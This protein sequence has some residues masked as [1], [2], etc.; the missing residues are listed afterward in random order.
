LLS[1]RFWEFYRRGLCIECFDRIEWV[2]SNT[3]RSYEGNEPQSHPVVEQARSSHLKTSFFITK[4][5][6]QCR[7]RFF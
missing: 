5:R 1:G 6:A 3:G 4:M 2:P 7:G